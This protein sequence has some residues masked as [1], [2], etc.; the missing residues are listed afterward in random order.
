V[1]LFEL[2]TDLSS[3]GQGFGGRTWWR[4]LS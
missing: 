4:C 3:L 2:F 1:G